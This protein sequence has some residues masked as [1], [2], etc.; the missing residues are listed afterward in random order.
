MR[1]DYD[2]I[3]IG[4]GAAGLVTA[5]GAAGLGARVALVEH[6]RMGG[7]CLWTGCVPSKALLACARAA[8]DARDAKRFGITTGAVAVDFARVMAHVHHARDT[9]APHDSPE[10]FRGLGVDVIEAR[11]RFVGDRALDIGGRTITGRHVV[12]A[13]GS[14]P[15]IPPIPGLRDVAYH[16]NE[17]IFEIA[18]F[19]E[20][21]I[22]LGGGPIG[23]ELA[24][25]FALLGSHVTLIEAELRI[26]MSEEP[27]L[28]E[29]IAQQ[30]RHDGVI[31]KLATRVERVEKAGAQIRVHAQG[32]TVEAAHLLIAV[33]REAVVDTLELAA[34]GIEYDRSGLK[35]DAR[36]RTSA[37]NVWAAG[38]VTG[39]PRFTHVAD[40]QARTVLRNALFPLTTNVNYDVV[41]RVTFTIPE[42]ASVGLTEAAA[43]ARHGESVRVFTR[44]FS[45]LD[46]AI[47]DGRTTGLL[48]I[49][50]D[51]KGRILGGHIVGYNAGGIIAEITLAM[52]QKIPLSAIAATMH[53]YPTYN[54]SV[55][56]AAD[57]F[58]R[59]GFAGPAKA[60]AGWLVRRA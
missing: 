29:M 19:P 16:T 42:L 31:L 21:L 8:A 45:G 47:A 51:R 12:I 35:L 43:R 22:V 54:E 53:A 7:E 56:H 37:K 33:G 36:L 1:A 2:L 40:Y 25:A 14:R 17:D 49:V 28:A 13:T 23:V 55:K 44:E 15:A 4:G 57:A 34:G 46:R 58:V 3:A 41:P 10:R 30:L 39:G 27:A 52:K 9:I 20:S 60:I 48:K 5:A 50:A 11:A 38:D 18:E 59:S 32:A 24:H 26:L 6:H